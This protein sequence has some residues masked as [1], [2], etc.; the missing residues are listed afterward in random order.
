MLP[1]K[2]LFLLSLLL[3]HAFY[4]QASAV[5]HSTQRLPSTT[6]NKR[7]YPDEVRL[8]YLPP[9]PPLLRPA[10]TLMQQLVCPGHLPLPPYPQDPIYMSAAR[11]DP[12][13]QAPTALTYTDSWG[14]KEAI[15][16]RE[17]LCSRAGCICIHSHVVCSNFEYPFFVLVLHTWYADN[18]FITCTCKQVHSGPTLQMVT[19]G[20][21]TVKS[22]ERKS[23]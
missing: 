5:P 1:G 13:T 3:R 19:L 18:C 2:S 14:E 15:F 21:T 9:P 17:G 23:R 10:L 7:N 20:N 16:A 22:M 12:E 6:T 4:P 8:P 11:I